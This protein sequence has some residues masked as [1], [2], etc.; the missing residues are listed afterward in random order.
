MSVELDE[1]N[2]LLI[3]VNDVQLVSV[4]DKSLVPQGKRHKYL[5]WNLIMIQEYD[6]QFQLSIDY[7]IDVDARKNEQRN[8][9]GDPSRF[10]SSHFSFLIWQ[11]RFEDTEHIMIIYPLLK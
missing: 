6:R 11:K 10:W 3:D 8:D 9:G 5:I 1:S 2:G 4:D 7:A